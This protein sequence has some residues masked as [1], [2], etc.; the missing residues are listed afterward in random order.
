MKNEVKES[1]KEMLEKT[2][3]ALEEIQTQEQKNLD[4]LSEQQQESG[5]GEKIQDDIDT[6]EIVI[7]SIEEAVNTLEE[8]N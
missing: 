5:K 4:E 7:G 2:K 8:L 1:I 6:L 3:I